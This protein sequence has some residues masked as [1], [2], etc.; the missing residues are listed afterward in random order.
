MRNDDKHGRTNLQGDGKNFIEVIEHVG[1]AITP[2]TQLE[3]TSSIKKILDWFKTESKTNRRKSKKGDFTSKIDKYDGIVVDY[4]HTTNSR[5]KGIKDKEFREFSD[6][7]LTIA[8]IAPLLKERTKI[9]GI[10]HTRKQETNRIEAMAT[11]LKRII[12]NTNIFKTDDSLEILPVS[13]RKLRGY[14]KKW[15]DPIKINTYND[16]RVAMSFAILGCFD[17]MGNGRP[18]L[19]IKNPS[20]C[21]KTFPNFF[22][23]LAEIRENSHSDL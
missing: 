14:M 17:L 20:C 18:W 10:G 5:G 21:A 4:T 16:H 9:M 6:T 8:A 13:T 12:G 7:F 22:E 15:K 19:S 1:A 2:H 23:A 3:P 11:E